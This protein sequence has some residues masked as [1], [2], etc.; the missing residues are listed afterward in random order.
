MLMVSETKPV[1]LYCLGT[2]NT[3]GMTNP[4]TPEDNSSAKTCPFPTLILSGTRTLVLTSLRFIHAFDYLNTNYPV[5]LKLKGI[6]LQTIYTSHSAETEINIIFLPL[7][8]IFGIPAHS[9]CTMNS[10][11]ISALV[12]WT[13]LYAISKLRELVRA[14]AIA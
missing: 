6:M 3:N 10:T 13:Q 9:I 14:S 2:V 4:V 1:P 12:L 8:T 7:L 5:C 11:A